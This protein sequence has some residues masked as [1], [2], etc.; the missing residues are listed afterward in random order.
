MPEGAQ[1]V[2]SLRAHEPLYRVKDVIDAWTEVV[3]SVPN[4]HL[5][6]GNSGGLT[7]LLVDRVHDRALTDSVHF[8]GRIGEDQLPAL[9][10]S[11]D[12]YVSTS[13]VDGTSV[14][15]LQAMASSCPV[16]VTDAPGNRNWITHG[17]SGYLYPP[18][19]VRELSRAILAALRNSA[20]NAAQGATQTMT[21]EALRIV[22]ERADWSR[23]QQLLRSALLPS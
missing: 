19:D 23:N 2:L 5:L 4:T 13:P 20:E 15:L 21:A 8:I 11:V 9:L 3:A 1:V 7:Q 16:L 18:A 10:R 22:R 14:T 17:V 12:L 6:I